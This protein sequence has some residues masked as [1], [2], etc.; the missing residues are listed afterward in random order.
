MKLTVSS[1]CGVTLALS[2]CRIHAVVSSTTATMSVLLS[3]VLLNDRLT[4]SVRVFFH[5]I[6]P[7]AGIRHVAGERVH[8]PLSLS[9][10]LSLSARAR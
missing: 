1:S 5:E 9:L 8:S 3:W 7:W 4:P 2:L 10:S 6:S